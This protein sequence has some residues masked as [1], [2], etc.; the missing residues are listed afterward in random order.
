M[1]GN[2]PECRA[3]FY[4]DADIG[5]GKEGILALHEVKCELHPCEA[6]V[7]ELV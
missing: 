7:V 5:T 3:Y 1:T 6:H 4:V 2:L